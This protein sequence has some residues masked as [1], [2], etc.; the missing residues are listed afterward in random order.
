MAL[1]TVTLFVFVGIFVCCASG[2][3]LH[4]LPCC[5]VDETICHDC[6]SS[7]KCYC[8]SSRKDTNLACNNGNLNL[9][10]G[11]SGRLICP[12]EILPECN[13][14]CAKNITLGDCGCPDCVAAIR[15]K[16]CQSFLPGHL[17]PAI[18]GRRG[19]KDCPSDLSKCHS[20]TN[21]LD[22]FCPALNQ[23]IKIVCSSYGNFLDL[24]NPQSGLPHCPPVSLGSTN[25]SSSPSDGKRAWC[26]SPGFSPETTTTTTTTF[27]TTTTKQIFTEVETS[28]T[29]KCTIQASSRPTTTAT[30]TST[31][32]TTHLDSSTSSSTSRFTDKQVD[33]SDKSDNTLVIGGGA[34]LL[35]LLALVGVG[36]GCWLR[37]RR[38][39]AEVEYAEENEMYGELPSI[40]RT[41]APP[42]DDAQEVENDM[43]GVV[44]AA[45][46]EDNELYG[47]FA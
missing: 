2:T 18:S 30:T 22:C 20:C 25:C 34:G 24:F 3:K 8:T 38:G 27:S 6:T 42:P 12:R 31:K 37:R 41:A 36:V 35:V 13:G 33:P 4:N 32:P 29:T 46:E 16:T 7:L 28:P 45:F 39:S 9:Y 10:D 11:R 44:P 43:Y 5:P 47:T 21:H 17:E 19:P 15:K 23:T 26:R 40:P 1:R 14:T